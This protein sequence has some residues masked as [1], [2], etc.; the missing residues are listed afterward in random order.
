MR[1]RALPLAFA[2]LAASACVS[3]LPLQEQAPRVAF[4]PAAPVVVSVID[5]RHWLARGKPNTFIGRRHDRFGIPYDM[6]VR[7]YVTGDWKHRKQ[8]LASALE[9]RIVRGLAGDDGRH[10]SPAGSPALSSD[11]EP[12]SA[13]AREPNSTLLVVI[14]REWFVSLSLGWIAPRPFNFDWAVD[15][16]VRSADGKTVKHSA[17][18]RDVIAA[19]YDQSYQNLIRIAYRERL[20]QLL[21]EPVVRAALEGRA[22][23]AAADPPGN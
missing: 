7:E 1:L 23:G 15:I 11:V 5:Q 4:E 12:R 2:V 10:A 13:L 18:G 20:T 3:N 6:N 14:L 22:E 19:D 8:S 16:E 9:E 17:G 21:E